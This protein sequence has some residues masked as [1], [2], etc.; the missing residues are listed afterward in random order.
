MSTHCC[1]FFRA[2]VVRLTSLKF[3]A[4]MTKSWSVFK[5]DIC[6]YH[7]KFF[8][9]SLYFLNFSFTDL[10]VINCSCCTCLNTGGWGDRLITTK[11]PK[12]LGPALDHMCRLNSG[13]RRRGRHIFFYLVVKFTH[14]RR[15]S[16]W[17]DTAA[18]VDVIAILYNWQT[19][20]TFPGKRAGLLKRSWH[21]FLFLP[22]VRWLWTRRTFP[23]DD[24]F[25]SLF[26]FNC[27]IWQ[28]TCT[29]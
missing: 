7:K 14:L 24:V 5:F 9:H 25:S 26:L 8:E 27:W 18:P 19:S 23:N 11:A 6:T 10:I 15:H 22:C 17:R 2:V 21:H 20:E 16:L 28:N 13:Q 4:A 29:M 12:R 3:R 1:Q